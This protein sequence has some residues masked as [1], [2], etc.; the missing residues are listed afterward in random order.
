MRNRLVRFWRRFNEENLLF[1]FHGRATRREFLLCLI[2]AITSLVLTVLVGSDGFSLL[3]A[4]LCFGIFFA[5]AAR[6]LHD[7]GSSAWTVLIVFVPYAGIGFLAV[8]ML[9]GGMEGPNEFGPDPRAKPQY[10]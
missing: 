9:K 4:L 7:A 6:R 3:V 8:I 10:Y 2:I 5:A 1:R